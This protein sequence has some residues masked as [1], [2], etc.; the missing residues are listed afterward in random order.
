MELDLDKEEEDVDVKA[1][2]NM[3]AISENLTETEGVVPP[4]DQRDPWERCMEQP[5]GH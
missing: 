1:G 4:T 2:Y 3:D 5:D